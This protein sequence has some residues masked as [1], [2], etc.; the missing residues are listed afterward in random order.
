MTDLVSREVVGH[1]RIQTH[2]LRRSAEALR[3]R[4]PSGGDPELDGMHREFHELLSGYLALVDGVIDA[5]RPDSPETGATV[6]RS[7]DASED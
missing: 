6:V 7:P 2:L 1:L 4:A 5:L 3:E